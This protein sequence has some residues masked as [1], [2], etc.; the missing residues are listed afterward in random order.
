MRAVL[1]TL[2][3]V[4]SFPAFAVDDCRAPLGQSPIDWFLGP[5]ADEPHPWVQAT[6]ITLDSPGALRGFG[7]HAGALQEALRKTEGCGAFAFTQVPGTLTF[8]TVSLWTSRESLRAFVD[9]SAHVG[10]RAGTEAR[11]GATARFA[12]W[13][14]ATALDDWKTVADRLDGKQE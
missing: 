9:G 8:R 5:A 13:R 11:Q 4:T 3:F 12:L 14:T 6:E 10:A 7:Q 2:V 1:L